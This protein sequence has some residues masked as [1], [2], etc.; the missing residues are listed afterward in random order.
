MPAAASI[1]RAM[2]VR[3]EGA[4]GFVRD[5]GSMLAEVREQLEDEAANYERKSTDQERGHQRKASL[6]YRTVGYVGSPVDYP[7]IRATLVGMN[8]NLIGQRFPLLFQT[9][10]GRGRNDIAVYSGMLSKRHAMIMY[11][12]DNYVLKDMG[13]TNGCMVN[14]VRTDYAKLVDGDTLQFGDAVFGF[15]LDKRP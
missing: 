9:S 1:L 14:R 5:D 4:A 13:S 8:L 2:V 7:P 10:I 11:I 12:D 3:I 15:E 6:A